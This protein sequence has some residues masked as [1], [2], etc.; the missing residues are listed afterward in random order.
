MASWWPAD[1]TLPDGTALRRCRVYITTTDLVVFTDPEVP[2]FEAAVD[3]AQ[4][5]Q[6]PAGNTWPRPSIDVHTDAGRAVVS[7]TGGCGCGH[8]LKRW[9]PDWASRR[10]PWRNHP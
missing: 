10:T 8:R 4:T 1:V 7:P 5:P 3:F 2:A 9:T 6:P